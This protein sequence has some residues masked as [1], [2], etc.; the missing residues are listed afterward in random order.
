VGHSGVIVYTTSTDLLQLGD[1]PIAQRAQPA[2][3]AALA[4]WAV[5]RTGLGGRLAASAWS[6]YG[7]TQ[8]S[9]SYQERQARGQWGILPYVSPPRKARYGGIGKF[10]YA[11][12]KPGIG[13]RVYNGT[14]TRDTASADLTV[15]A[16]RGLNFSRNG[17]VYLEE[18]GH[19]YPADSAGIE[20]R[21][22]RLVDQAIQKE[23]D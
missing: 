19:L 15:P 4:G 6:L 10:L 9:P 11:L 18:W 7:W 1:A 12:T 17:G 20:P 5:D 13:H 3:A 14:A 21:L 23:L 8:R 16:A 22:Y 2:V